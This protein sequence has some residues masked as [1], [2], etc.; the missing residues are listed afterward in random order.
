MRLAGLF[1]F[2]ALTAMG[3][4]IAGKW[5]ATYDEN[6]PRDVVFTF[7]VNDG[8]ITGTAIGPQGDAP[9]A[10]KI[11][12]NKV[13]FTVERDDFKAVVTG[14]IDGDEMKLTAT[15]GRRTVILAPKRIR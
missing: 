14:T 3:A 9:L 6:G 10:G 1:L 11:E 12:G 2:A 4:D 15:V 7:Q 8:K 5:K 13:D